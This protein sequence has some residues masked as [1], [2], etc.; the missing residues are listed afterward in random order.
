MEKENTINE[1]KVGEITK[2]IMDLI[3]GKTV[4]DAYSEAMSMVSCVF[5][6]VFLAFMDNNVAELSE[7]TKQ[8]DITLDDFIKNT[9]RSVYRLLNESNA[10]H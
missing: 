7:K 8:L 10:L 6:S 2:I 4:E 3:N 1:E 9:R 5:G